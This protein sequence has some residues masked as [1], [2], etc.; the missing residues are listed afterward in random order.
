MH[1]RSVPT[2]TV[3]VEATQASGCAWT[4]LNRSNYHH[5]V[6]TVKSPERRTSFT[7]LPT[8]LRARYEHP[9]MCVGP[10]GATWEHS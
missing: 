1:F 3:G 6:P 2:V 4:P 9:A 10:G 5:S 8:E 7:S